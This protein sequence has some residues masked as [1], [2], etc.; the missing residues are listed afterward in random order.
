MAIEHIQELLQRGIQAAKQGDRSTARRLLLQVVDQAPNNELAWIWLA[1]V[2]ETIGQRRDYLERVLVI[3]PNNTRARQALESIEHG[4]STTNDQRPLPPPPRSDRLT[5]AERQALLQ[6][7]QRRQRRQGRLSPF[8]FGILTVLALFL[9]A[10]GF[11]LFWQENLS[12]DT[13]TP[14]DAQGAIAVLPSDTPTPRYISPTPGG[15]TRT[16][17]P[18]ESPPPTWTPT[19]TWTPTVI[20]TATVTPPPLTEYA[21]LFTKQTSN[22]SSSDLF[23]ILGDGSRET[24][25]PLS[26]SDDDRAAGLRVL[27]VSDAAYSPD[28]TRIVMSAIIGQDESSRTVQDLFIVPAEGGEMRRITTLQADHVERATW[29]PSGDQIAFASDADG[30]FDIYVTSVDGNTLLKLTDHPGED[31]DPAWS[32]TSDV[33][34]YATDLVGP[35]ELEIYS[36]SSS[37]ENLKRLTNN[38]NSSFAPAWSP[39][40]SQIVFVSS[41]RGNNDLYIMTAEGLGQSA[42]LVRDVSAEEFDPAWSPDG[43]WIAFSSDREGSALDLFLIRP[44]GS[45]IERLT[46]GDGVTNSRYP[47]WKP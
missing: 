43:M 12:D 6:R 1:S 37:G 29:S 2:A 36:M 3:N 5:L 31:R 40:G 38:V 22:Q 18:V 39:D 44:D 28:G 23:T 47:D 10:L 19:A 33:I 16:P 35:G 11:L 15:P 34:V 4:T 26:I 13:A 46:N 41:R 21:L 42:I 20:P 17:R 45:S 32:P 30:D 14:T 25:I 27:G 8:S 7:K 24:R 9:I